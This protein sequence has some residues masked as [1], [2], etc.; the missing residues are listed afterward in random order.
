MTKVKIWKL[1]GRV[2]EENRHSCSFVRDLSESEVDDLRT[3]F[4]AIHELAEQRDLSRV[5]ESGERWGAILDAAQV[6]I[7]L[8]G[9]ISNRSQRVAWLELNAFVR[10]GERLVERLTDWAADLPTRP[11]QASRKFDERRDRLRRNGPYALLVEAFREEKLAPDPL[12]PRKA[13]DPFFVRGFEAYGARD[14]VAAALGGMIELVIAYFT[15]REPSYRQLA[16]EMKSFTLSVPKGMPSIFSFV[17]T[18]PGS[19]PTKYQMT[20]FPV[21]A[22]TRL[23][24][25][26]DGV[27][28]GRGAGALLEMLQGR[29]KRR[30]S[31]G[32]ASADSAAIGGRSSGGINA[33]PTATVQLDVDLL[34][35]EPV[36]YWAPVRDRVEEGGDGR[37]MFTGVVQQAVP[38]GRVVSLECEGAIALLEQLAGGTLA[39][40]ME[41]AELLRAMERCVGLDKVLPL[42]EE[43]PEPSEEPFE[44]VVPLSGIDVQHAIA[45]GNASLIPKDDGAK[46]VARLS[47]DDVGESHAA[48]IDEFERASCY[49]VAEALAA[50]IDE[51]ENLGLLAIDTALAWLTTRGRYGAATLPNGDPQ[52]FDRQKALRAPDRGPVVLVEGTKT[53][54]FWLRRPAPPLNAMGRRLDA[55][56]DSL[57]PRLP[58][59]L[60]VNDRLALLALRLAASEVDPLMQIRALWQ[61]IESYAEKRKGERKL[62]DKRVRKSILTRLFEDEP[63]DLDDG[64]RKRLEEAIKNLNRGPLKQRLERRLKEDAVL[65]TDEELALL[66]E[67]YD[68]RNDVVHGRSVDD[69]PERDKIYYGISIV[70]RM[71]VHRVAAVGS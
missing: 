47:R 31:F 51:A 60:E 70:A 53:K 52:S 22:L 32:D 66:Q 12:Q 46:K 9:R 48:L 37:D 30:L 57:L 5:V 35:S 65:I 7:E 25:A 41:E 28:A 44:I 15:L 36:D 20:D 68:V 19:A 43:A 45:V 59:Q 8:D 16:N 11:Q 21:L 1:G 71:L 6:E 27:I 56:D 58:A 14:L 38:D 23:D 63:L 42:N 69:P 29:Y 64:Q 50:T 55:H 61:A 24:Q 26:F 10:L 62:F 39:A 13:P 34:G 2:T 3:R 4:D 67:L 49:L 40:N 33:V 17:E 18:G 54:R